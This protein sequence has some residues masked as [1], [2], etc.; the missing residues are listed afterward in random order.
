MN[1][2]KVLENE[3]VPVYETSTGEKVVYG[4]ELY[5]VL[6]VKSKFA[7]W[8]K[9]RLKDCDALENEDFQS[10]SKVLE[11]GGRPQTEY[12]IKL[13]IAK[14]MAMLERNDKGKQVR[15]YFI[16]VE[17]RYKE[18]LLA[19]P[20][21]YPSALRSLADEYEKRQLAEKENKELKKEISYKEDVITGLTDEITLADKRQILN[22]VVRYKNANYRDRW[23]VLYREFENKFHI[24]LQYRYD[25][26]NKKHTPKCTSKLDYI[27]KIMGKIPELYEIATKLYENDVNALV[28]EM[29]GVT[30][31][32][33]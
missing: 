12:I 5:G 21:D 4:T 10:F 28:E 22:R 17:K 32:N 3:L 26:H 19:T 13:D 23:G 2:L 9:N 20:K 7:D 14:E 25:T 30:S 16:E 18:D 11:K 27:D 29:Y 6:K 24:N 8:V 33:K 31:K 15:R 1:N